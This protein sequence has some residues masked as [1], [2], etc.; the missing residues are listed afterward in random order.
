[1]KTQSGVSRSR[2]AAVLTAAVLAMPLAAC[3]AGGPTPAGSPTAV[4]SGA[5]QVFAAYRDA[6]RCLRS[7]GMPG[8]PDPV[9]V[10]GQPEVPADAPKPPRAAIDAC[11]AEIRKL[12]DVGRDAPATAADIAK[13]R[14]FAACMREHGLPDWPDPNARGAFPL[15]RRLFDLGKR[16]FFSQMQACKPLAPKG[17]SIQD[18]AGNG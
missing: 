17:I 3:S 15:P 16:G 4:P 9:M 6:V 18:P 7:H 14:Q 2:A 10:S 5:Q 11:Q 1:M 13:L 12:P 8:F